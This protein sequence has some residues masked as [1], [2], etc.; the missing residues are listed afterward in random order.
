M[1]CDCVMLLEA[2]SHLCYLMVS[3]SKIPD[4]VAVLQIRT[5][6][7][8]FSVI[9]FKQF[10]PWQ[11]GKS[12][13]QVGVWWFKD[14]LFGS[15]L[16]LP[17]TKPT[18]ILPDTTENHYRLKNVF[19]GDGGYVSSFPGGGYLVVGTQIWLDLEKPKLPDRFSGRVFVSSSL[20]IQFQVPKDVE[21]VSIS[22]FFFRWLK[23][24]SNDSFHFQRW[25]SLERKERAEIQ[26][27]WCESHFEVSVAVLGPRIWSRSILG[28]FICL[29]WLWFDIM[30]FLTILIWYVYM[31]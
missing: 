30:W 16:W 7:L 2:V 5:K 13:N 3:L 15:Q 20:E 19:P 14:I 27:N 18:Y 4:Q 26:A 12:S 10:P 1:C 31:G 9:N 24:I 17:S 11:K 21:N 25:A 23:R 29:F 22:M 28:D 6:C 8:Y